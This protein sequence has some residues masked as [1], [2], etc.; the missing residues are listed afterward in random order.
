VRG[1]RRKLRAAAA[2]PW[3][4]VACMERRG[5]PPTSVM[6]TAAVATSTC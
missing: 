5:L 2:A 3:A 1:G 4:I 6:R